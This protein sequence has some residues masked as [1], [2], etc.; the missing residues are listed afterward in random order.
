MTKKEVIINNIQ[1]YLDSEMWKYEGCDLGKEDLETIVD[2]LEQEPCE[3]C[4]SRQAVI[5]IWHTQYAQVRQE[6][7]EIKY[8]KIAYELPSV[9]PIRPKGKWIDIGNGTECSICHEI[10][11]GYDNYRSFCSNCGADMRGKED[12]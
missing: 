11:Y 9:Q 8:K 12:K 5:D 4:I 6:D 10:Q 3:D 2:A 7:E 1:E